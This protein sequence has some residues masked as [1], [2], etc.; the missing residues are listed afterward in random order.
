MLGGG[1]DYAGEV[2]FA[3][4]VCAKVSKVQICPKTFVHDCRL[5]FVTK[6]KGESGTNNLLDQQT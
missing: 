2:V 4:A 6:G 3:S 1:R 5:L